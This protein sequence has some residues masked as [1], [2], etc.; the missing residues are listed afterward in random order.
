[1]ATH[2]VYLREVQMSEQRINVNAATVQELTQLPG[3]GPVL[4]ERIATYRDTVRLFE[5]PAQITMVSGIG[6]RTYGAIADRL[7]VAAPEELARPALEAPQERMEELEQSLAEP[8]TEEATE[9]E[10]PSEAEARSEEEILPE[11]EVE[12]EVKA[13][14][15]GEAMLEEETTFAEGQPP[16]EVS[17]VAEETIEEAPLE[18][19]GTLAEKKAAPEVKALPSGQPMLEEG[20]TFAEEAAEGEAAEMA[21]EAD[22]IPEEITEEAPP[23]VSD[24]AEEA[25]EKEAPEPLE[26]LTEEEA[27]PE[28]GEEPADVE[29]VPLESGLPP[30]QAEERPEPAP[31]RSWWRRLSWLWTA[32]LGGLLGMAFALVVLSGINGSLDVGHSRA[33]VDVRGRMDSLTTDINSLQGDVDGLR[34]RLD[35]LEEL[36]VR[37]DRAEAAVGDLQEA[38]VGLGERADALEESVAAV[39]DELDAVSQQVETLQEQAEQT[40]SFFQALQTLLNDFFGEAAEGA[41]T[42]TPTPTPEGK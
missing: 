39:G 34:K 24:V 25:I 5:E 2:E 37:M 11:E 27:A 3:I 40:R 36:T 6:E 14:P 29:A 41:S 16:P 30:T 15:A 38:T 18:A 26:M 7:A 32:L 35:A 33:V 31:S 9:E 12:P 23:E 17:D 42:V 13:V 28:V 1:M 10:T 21:P 22:R 20:L 4:A 8:A 19:L